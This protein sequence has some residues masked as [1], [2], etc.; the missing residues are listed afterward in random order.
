MPPQK[1]SGNKSVKRESGVVSK[2]RKFIQSFLEDV[3]EET[4]LTD[5]FVARIIKKMG[6]GRVQAFYVDN[7][8]FPHIVQAI[9]RGSF[10]GKGKR[11][12]WIDD[13]SIVILADSGIGGSAEYE[14]MAVLSP[15]EVRDLRKLKEI[16]PRI[17]AT[18]IIDTSQLMSDKPIS[19]ESGFEFDNIEPT[20][21]EIN[22]I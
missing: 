9:I 18:N 3:R 10:R 20:E 16:D 13:N 4:N 14:I 1:N 15:D 8:H 11:S 22:D 7:K 12:V 21:E 17:L 19:S 2:N 6:N 5:V